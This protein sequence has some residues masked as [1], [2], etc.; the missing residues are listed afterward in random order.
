MAS[1]PAQSLLPRRPALVRAMAWEVYAVRVLER[2]PVQAQD[3]ATTGRGCEAAEVKP[4]YP[5]VMMIPGVQF[6]TT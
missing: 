2:A 3:P 1:R 6:P 5:Q 4:G